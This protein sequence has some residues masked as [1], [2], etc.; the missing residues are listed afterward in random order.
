MSVI[1]FI[2]KYEDQTGKTPLERF[3]RIRRILRTQ[4]ID[5]EYFSWE[6]NFKFAQ[7][8]AAQLIIF[9]NLILEYK[10][11]KKVYD[12]LIS[13]EYGKAGLQALEAGHKS[14]VSIIA[15]AG[16]FSDTRRI[17]DTNGGK[18]TIELKE[19]IVS[20]TSINFLLSS[21]NLLYRLLGSEQV[22]GTLFADQVETNSVTNFKN[23]VTYID[24][25]EIFLQSTIYNSIG[26]DDGT[27]LLDLDTISERLDEAAIYCIG[28]QQTFYDGMVL[29][30]GKRRGSSQMTPEFKVLYDRI[31]K[32]LR[33]IL[34]YPEFNNRLDKPDS[35]V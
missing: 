24:D 1:D 13:P 29:D 23:D 16:A 7:N 22:F 17:L 33:D 31:N 18:V 3:E 14:D 9:A 2:E 11:F 20:I 25:I 12:Y 26:L 21:L 8:S 6:M 35:N 32:D 19:K 10:S 34:D 5:S 27:P 4:P 28:T 15:I 30:R